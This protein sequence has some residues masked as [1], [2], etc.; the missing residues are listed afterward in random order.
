MCSKS[1]ASR[2]C[3]MFIHFFPYNIIQRSGK[4]DIIWDIFIAR[5]VNLNNSST[6]PRFW[7]NSIGKSKKQQATTQGL[8]RQHS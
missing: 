8:A 7:D 6:L 1:S 4:S 2:W 3:E 5:L